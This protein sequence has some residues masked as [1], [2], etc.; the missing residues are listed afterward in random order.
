MTFTTI[1]FLIIIF[2][3][4]EYS[5]ESKSILSALL[6]NFMFYWQEKGNNLQNQ[7]NISEKP[8][9]AFNTWVSLDS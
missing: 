3:L 8:P 7:S 5:F 4:L 1:I 6:L 2:K 9:K